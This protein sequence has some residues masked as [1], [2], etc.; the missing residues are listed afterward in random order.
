MAETVGLILSVVATAASA[1]SSYSSERS[2]SKAEDRA[3]RQQALAAHQ[4]RQAAAQRAADEEKRHRMII[5]SQKARYAAL[6]LEQT[7]TPL[8]V[9]L[10]S[11]R[12]SEEQLRRIKEGGE[13]AYMTGME[14]AKAAG[15][16]ARAATVSGYVGGIGQAAAGTYKIGKYDWW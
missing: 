11:L 9:E 1:Y 8:L 5:A 2:Q 12:E 10:E 13:V 15:E 6:G 14:L 3:K 4:A 7:G 16:R